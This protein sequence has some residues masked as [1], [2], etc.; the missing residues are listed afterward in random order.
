[1]TVRGRLIEIDRSGDVA[2]IEME[3]AEGET[4]V[5]VYELIG[6]T[7][8]PKE[9]KASTEMAIW[10]PDKARERVGELPSER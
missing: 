6:W 5:G 3:T 2:H 4:V 9:V 1:M 7:T 8:P 10:T